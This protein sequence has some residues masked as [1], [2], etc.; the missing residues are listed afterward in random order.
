MGQLNYASM[1]TNPAEALNADLASCI[2]SVDDFPRN[3]DKT[4]PKKKAKGVQ[5]GCE[6]TMAPGEI[7]RPRDRAVL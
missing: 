3:E 7:S 4:L 6:S 2:I 1:I 5:L